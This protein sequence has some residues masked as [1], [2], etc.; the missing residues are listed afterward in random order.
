METIIKYRF[1]SEMVAFVKELDIKTAMFGYD[2][3]DVYSKFKDLLVRSRD[4][5]EELVTEK[6]EEI[7]LMKADLIEAAKHPDKLEALILRWETDPEIEEED[8]DEPSDVAMQETTQEEAAPETP[9]QAVDT[10]ELIISTT[11][12][13]EEENAQLLDQLATLTVENESLS[14]Q[15][16]E[17]IEREEV[18]KM[19]D[20]I[21]TE[22]RLEGEE[23]FRKARVHAEQELFLYRA[24]RREEEEAFTA[25][26]TR[27]EA[28]KSDLGET[29]ASYREYIRESQ[30]LFERLKS[31][32]TDFEQPKKSSCADI[33][34]Q[35][36]M[37][38]EIDAPEPSVHFDSG[39]SEQA[40]PLCEF[41]E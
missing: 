32:T 6:Y 12:A 16:A 17:Y 35:E 24:K 31:F 14:S 34:Q 26:L 30:S 2:K 3:N 25:E 20:D 11:V 4:V 15:L 33:A 27:M 37:Q 39:C 38:I 29:C 1:D 36:D 18:L 19:A 21:V 22:A 41:E 9:Q 10:D 23:I 5:C 13:Y 40:Q 8:R 7:E 28:E